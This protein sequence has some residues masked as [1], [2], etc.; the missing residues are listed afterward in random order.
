MPTRESPI[1]QVLMVLKEMLAQRR[2]NEPFSGGL[3][4]YALLLLVEALVKERAVIREELERVEKQ[5]R[6]VAAGGGNSTLGDHN[7]QK[8]GTEKESSRRVNQRDGNSGFQDGSAPSGQLTVDAT[9]R[10]AAVVKSSSA[11]TSDGA[12]QRAPKV[13]SDQ[14][15]PTLKTAAS[16]SSW[17]SV[18]KKNTS[19]GSSQKGAL[20]QQRS[21][22]PV[23]VV[24]STPSSH[25]SSVKPKVTTFAD[26]VARSADVAKVSAGADNKRP[27]L[28]D[29]R[30]ESSLK[31]D[32]ATSRRNSVLSS[33]ATPFDAR[34]VAHAQ[35]ASNLLKP[36]VAAPSNEA[37]DQ[38]Q[39]TLAPLNQ[40]DV[41]IDPSLVGV[42]Q[43]F[44]QGSN[45]V[46]EVLCSG[47]TTAG[48]LLMHF[49]LFYGQ[50]F[51]ARTIAIDVSGKHT[52]VNRAANGS[53]SYLPLSPYIQRRQG[54]TID[55]ISGM[56]TVDPIV[57]YDPLEGAE[58]NN[59]A[60][61]CFLWSNIRWVF[62]QSYNTLSSAVERSPTPPT[63]PG[64]K[65]QHQKVLTTKATGTQALEAQSKLVKIKHCKE[66]ASW[67]TTF[68]RDDEGQ[69][70]VDSPLLELLLSF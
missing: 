11:E 46:V 6:V 54:G 26:A 39:Q 70:P 64:R 65:Q 2:L 22:E 10:K 18:A 38:T 68:V 12:A 66:M 3:S 62:A 56:L 63:T 58:N 25:Q 13:A 28:F 40:S 53:A 4:S 45:D 41:S 5:R 55:P 49:L 19:F 52:D 34:Q 20:E 59:V 7:V 1:V 51:D 32:S 27:A 15:P 17:A 37:F 35:P 36:V 69:P 33:D 61:S 48:K 29:D 44:P 16:A 14:V 50:H 60:R 47:D 24:R 21:D 23:S 30:I 57:V 9:S 31:T 8:V 67:Q 42:P 43:L